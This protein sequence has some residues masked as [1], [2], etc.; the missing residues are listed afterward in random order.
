MRFGA[1]ILTQVAGATLN[2]ILLIALTPL[3]IHSLGMERYGILVLVLSLSIYLGILDFGASKAVTFHIC[4][5]EQSDKFA[6]SRVVVTALALVSPLSIIAGVL[7]SLASTETTGRLIGLSPEAITELSF[8]APALFAIGASAILSAVPAAALLGLGQFIL[9]NVVNVSTTASGLLFPAA[10]IYAFGSNVDIAITGTAI[11]R[12]ATLLLALLFLATKGLTLKR[13]CLSAKTAYELLKYGKWI[14][15]SNLLALLSSHMDRFLIGAAATASS[16]AYYSI[17]ESVLSRLGIVTNALSTTFFV[18]LASE[19][20]NGIAAGVHDYYRL[21]L[22]TAP[23]YV[24]LAGFFGPALSLWIGSEFSMVA[25]N[26]AVLLA[27]SSWLAA[28]NYTPYTLLQAQGKSR[29]T[30]TIAALTFAPTILALFVMIKMWGVLGAA[31]AATVRSLLLAAFHIAASN[32]QGFP[33]PV[34]TLHTCLV[35]SAAAVGLGFD[36]SPLS[37]GALLIILSFSIWLSVATRPRGLDPYIQRTVELV[38][39]WRHP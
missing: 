17:P 2:I 1:Q 34:A 22:M 33:L 10:A 13:S 9:L 39:R 5:C 24:S 23:L 8:S 6:V 20:Q 11:A 12:V 3:L 27:V 19:A 28:I 7:F 18:R 31:I 36:P 15:L 21:V 30:A 38:R 4:R 16:V 29:V 32:A 37:A 14:G 35:L 26:V 25:K